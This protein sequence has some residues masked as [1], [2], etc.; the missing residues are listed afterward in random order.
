MA[1]DQ[2]H[3]GCERV[4]FANGEVAEAPAGTTG[5]QV[6]CHLLV[7]AQAEEGRRQDVVGSRGK[8]RTQ[9]VDCRCSV[10]CR[11]DSLHY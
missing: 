11:Y 10:L 5:Q 9:V 2:R 8:A 6:L 7:G 1:S 4:D 3:D